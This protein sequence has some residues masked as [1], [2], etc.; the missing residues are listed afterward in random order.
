MKII[1]FSTES[2]E[3]GQDYDLNIFFELTDTDYKKLIKMDFCDILEMYEHCKSISV[4]MYNTESFSD[5]DDLTLNGS[6]FS[7]T[8]GKFITPEFV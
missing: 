3:T 1:S 7:H 2:I 4:G 6:V 5:N 8:D